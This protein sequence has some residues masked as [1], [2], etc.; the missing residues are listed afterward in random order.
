MTKWDERHLNT[1]KRIAEERS[2]DPSTK[3]GAVLVSPFGAEILNSFN[4]IPMGVG[5]N[6]ERLERPLKYLF[7]AHAEA[8]LIAFAARHGIRTEGCSVYITHAPCADCAKLL[9]QAGIKKVYHQTTPLSGVWESS[10]EAA[11]VMMD[12][13][14]I[15]CVEVPDPA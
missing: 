14:G 2:K 7:T 12:E 4:G 15:R 6:P 8:N 3:V 9:I 10:L 13:A 11:Y 5:D 1:A